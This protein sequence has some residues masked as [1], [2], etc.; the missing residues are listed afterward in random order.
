MT[1]LLELPFT[2]PDGKIPTAVL[3]R[4][5]DAVSRLPGKPF[6]LTLKEQKRKRSLNQ[7]N[8]YFGVV[9]PAVTG[10]FREHGNYYDEHDVHEFLKLRVGKLAQNMLMPDGEVVKSLGS[11]AKL[12][13]QEF[14]V[15]MEKIRAWAAEYGLAIPLPREVNNSF[16]DE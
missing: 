16:T 14:E 3:H 12:T 11:T 8:Y 10:M 15:Y 9:V 6:V 13:T 5:M 4:L 7:N 2:A 1:S